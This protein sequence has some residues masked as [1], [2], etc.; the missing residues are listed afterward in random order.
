VTVLQF[1]AASALIVAVGVYLYS[2][3]RLHQVIASEQPQWV[4]RKGTLSF[5]YTGMPRVAD[6]NVSLAVLG[7]AFSSKARQLSAVAKP[8]VR[9]IRVLLPLVLL[10]FLGVLVVSVV[11]AP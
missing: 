5:F 3:Y 11:G 7:V 4:D 6:P 1:L 10:F 9:C 8:Y 2:V